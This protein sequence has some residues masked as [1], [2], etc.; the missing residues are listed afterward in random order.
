V[1][2]ER[3][4]KLAGKSQMLERAA[5]LTYDGRMTE[6]AI[7]AELG[8]ARRTLV[9]WKASPE[10]RA[11]I[12]QHRAAARQVEI[13]YTIADRRKRVALLE[14]RRQKLQDGFD[15]II[16]ERGMEM[17]G[18]PGGASGLLAR[19]YKQIGAGE[20][21]EKVEEYK[22]DP[23]ILA[24]SQELRELERQAAIELGQWQADQSGEGEDG[25]TLTDI[26]VLMRVAQR[27]VRSGGAYGDSSAGV[28]TSTKLIG[29]GRRPGRPRKRADTE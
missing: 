10:F 1:S 28:K 2:R 6:E 18:V 3:Q 4:P 12:E 16:A 24:I 22:I 19:Q 13:Q 27:R 20:K 29:S 14:S 11:L 9:R 23:G 8:I 5:R 25:F 26:A 7:A 15:R 21:T 17:A